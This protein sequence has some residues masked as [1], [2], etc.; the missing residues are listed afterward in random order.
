MEYE[1]RIEDLDR[2]LSRL[3]SDSTTGTDNLPR[4][5]ELMLPVLVVWL[6]ATRYSGIQSSEDREEVRQGAILRVMEIYSTKFDPAR[7]HFRSWFI[8]VAKRV[9]QEHFRAMINNQNRLLNHANEDSIAGLERT[10]SY[11][12]MKRERYAHIE[13]TIKELNLSVEQNQVLI[14]LIEGKSNPDMASALDLSMD[15]V[16][17]TRRDLM[18]R[19]K[20]ESGGLFELEAE[21]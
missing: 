6:Q 13:R 4:M 16:K 2:Q 1:E 18:R 7:G 17:K 15:E 19:L 21:L 20:K 9:C 5:I 10:A 12:L 11:K 14:G 8:G 3:C